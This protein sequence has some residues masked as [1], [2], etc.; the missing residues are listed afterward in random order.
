MLINL[1][2]CVSAEWF[3]RSQMQLKKAALHDVSYVYASR[4]LYYYRPQCVSGIWAVTSVTHCG[5]KILKYKPLCFLPPTRCIYW[6]MENPKPYQAHSSNPDPRR[7][8]RWPRPWTGRAFRWGKRTPRRD[9][10]HFQKPLLRSGASSACAPSR[11]P[12]PAAPPPARR[13]R[14]DQ[15]VVLNQQRDTTALQPFH[16]TECICI[17]T[18]N[19]TTCWKMRR[20]HWSIRKLWE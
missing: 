18:H 2:R 5:I 15:R 19:D 14:R 1:E 8:W 10:E 20:V 9:P 6:G 11:H 12:A 3:R 16:S 13:A 17:H 4:H 7:T